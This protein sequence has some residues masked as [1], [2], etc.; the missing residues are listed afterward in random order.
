MCIRDRI[1]TINAPQKGLTKTGKEPSVRNIT[2][3]ISSVVIINL[4]YWDCI[5][6]H[7]SPAPFTIPS[8]SS[9]NIYFSLAKD[10]AEALI[11][12]R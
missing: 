7:L 6:S 1:I 12:V 8:I 2:M 9:D 5:A 11:F 10:S 3:I 4:D